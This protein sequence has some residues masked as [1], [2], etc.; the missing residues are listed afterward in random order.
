MA[1]DGHPSWSRRGPMTSVLALFMIIASVMVRW[2]TGCGG[3]CH[4]APAPFVRKMLKVQERCPSQRNYTRKL[5][6]PQQLP[7]WPWPAETAITWSEQLRT[8]GN[9]ASLMLQSRASG[10]VQ[11]SSLTD[12][13]AM[14]RQ[15]TDWCKWRFWANI[16]ACQPRAAVS[17]NGT[18]A[19]AAPAFIVSLRSCTIAF[20]AVQ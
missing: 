17:S 12:I 14:P 3:A 2:R 10:S 7:F 13:M 15:P 20:T 18:D 4:S 1:I 8:A 11:P 6:W 16:Q 9:R 5:A 19:L